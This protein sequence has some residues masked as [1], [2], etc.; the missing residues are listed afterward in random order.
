MLHRSRRNAA[1][2]SGRPQKRKETASF[3]SWTFVGR[4][5]AIR[6]ALPADCD[7]AY[8]AILLPS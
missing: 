8:T 5:I 2:R 7:A 1:A 6:P 3:V 4:P